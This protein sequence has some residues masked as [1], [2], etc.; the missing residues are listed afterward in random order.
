MPDGVDGVWG[1]FLFEMRPAD[2]IRWRGVTGTLMRTSLK[3]VL[4]G[5][6][7]VYGVVVRVVVRDASSM[8]SEQLLLFVLAD[9]G[10]AV[11]SLMG[12]KFSSLI[13]AARLTRFD[14]FMGG[15]GSAGTSVSCCC[16]EHGLPVLGRSYQSPLQVVSSES[17]F[18]V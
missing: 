11:S 16:R 10:S 5:V 7:G 1:V 13:I 18:Q 4:L 2:M 8:I 9:S 14:L 12:S 3:R 17:S 6:M 15:R